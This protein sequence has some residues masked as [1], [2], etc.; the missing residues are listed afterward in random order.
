MLFGAQIGWCQR[1]NLT[2]RLPRGSVGVCALASWVIAV[3]CV[4]SPVLADFAEGRVAYDAKDYNA[5]HAEFRKAA[6]QGHTGAQYFLGEM[7]RRGRGVERNRMEAVSWY[8][9]AADQGNARAQFR[10]G[11]MYRR[12]HGVDKDS[13]EGA[14]WYRKAAEQGHAMAQYNLGHVYRS[15]Q[16][17]PRN[18]VEAYMWYSLFAAQRPNDQRNWVLGDMEEYMTPME[19]VEAKERAKNRQPGSGK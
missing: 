11:L 15:G 6:E 16:G 18:M 14:R 2:V 7:Y 13:A 4:A 10:L 1:M 9:K 17:V 8:R 5:A 12:G 3:A 19:V